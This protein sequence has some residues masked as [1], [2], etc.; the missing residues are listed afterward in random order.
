MMQLDHLNLY[1]GDLGKSRAFYEALLPRFGQQLVRDHGEIAVGFGDRN[2][3]VLALL[4]YSGTVQPTHLA[5]RCTTREEVDEA[6]ALAL[7]LGADDHGAPGLRP[8]YHERYY[9]GFVLDP[10]GHNLEFVCHE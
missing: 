8:H 1:V 6:H 10:D 3:A 7:S 9:A 5:F 2:Y 4:P